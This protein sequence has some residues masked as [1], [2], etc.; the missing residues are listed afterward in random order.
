ME[1]PPA[2]IP[3]RS[4]QHGLAEASGAVFGEHADLRD[5]A[6]I[7]AHQRAE[8][9][10]DERARAALDNNE[11]C[12]GI[13]SAASRKAH[14]VV[15]K[16]QRAGKGAVLIVDLGIDVAAVGGSDQGGGGLIFLLGPGTYFELRRKR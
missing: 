15:E 2:Q 10:A 12:P 5:V 13:K 8:N 7:G 14:D 4:S 6:N 11:G 9:E 16:A 1:S 3:G